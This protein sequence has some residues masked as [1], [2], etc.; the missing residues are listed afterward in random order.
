MTGRQATNPEDGKEIDSVKESI[1]DIINQLQDI[2][3]ARL[4][5]SPFLDLDTQISLAPVSDS[6]ESSVEELHSSSHS[7]MGSHHSLE[8]LPADQLV[9]LDSCHQQPSEGF[10]AERRPQEGKEGVQ[11]GTISSPI[12]LV[13]NLEDPVENCISTPNIAS[14]RD[15][16]NGTDTQRWSPESNNLESTIDEGQP[17]LGLPPES[18]EL[19]MWSSQDQETCEA[20]PE[21]ADK[22]L[23]CCCCRCCQSGRVPAVCSV[24]ASLLITAGLLYALYFYVPIDSPD[25]PDMVSRLTFTLCCCAVAA[26]PILLAML[27]GAM[28]QFCTGSLNPAEALHRRPAIQQL[29]VSASMEQ[30]FLYVLNLLVLATFLPQDQLRV[31]PIL[32]GVFV[33][34]RLI[35][36][37]CFHI[38]SPWRGFG[39]GLTV[40]P[41]LAMVAFNLYCLYDLS[42]RQL[43]FGSEDTLYYQTTPSSWPLEVSQSSSGKSD[44]VIPTDILETQ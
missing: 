36:W 39:S 28:C 16:P 6:P 41:L 31:V 38:C 18:I 35:Y 23:W 11:D 21:V 30:L 42:L 33:G 34:G 2:D 43:L 13:Q 10:K 27:I 24:L 8:A 1:S 14:R 17:L 22:R 15:I 12:A 3:P 25:C 37:L 44:S 32:T 26:V 20:V 4:S 5:F 9:Q 7:V 40:F 19:T 29:F